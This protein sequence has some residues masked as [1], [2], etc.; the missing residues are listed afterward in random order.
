MSRR[1]WALFVVLGIV[2]GLPYLLIRVSV[3][4]VS[5]ALLVFVRT[6]GGAALLAPF[7]FRRGALRP[8]L[9]HWKP[10]VLYSAVE[11]AGP[12]LLLFNAE[13]RL[14][15]S[16]A[17]LLVAAVP[18][19]GAGLAQVTGTDRLDRHRT[20]GL[21]LGIAGVA[22]LVG[23]DVRGS[24]L[25]SALSILVVAAGYALGPWILSRHLSGLPAMAVVGGSLVLCAALYAPVV[26][27]AL[28][29]RPLSGE[30]VA[31]MAALTVVCTV[32][33]FLVF[34]ALIAEVGAL[35]ATVITYVNTAVA[36]LLGVTVLGEHFGVGT[37]VGFVLILGGSFL[38]T[39]PLRTT[40][41]AA[42]PATG[43]AAAEDVPAGGPS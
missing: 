10:L 31:A 21:A 28:P 13:R 2:W 1:G 18:I 11:I 34:Y 26:P 40:V 4:E 15:S 29:S 7:A 42:A 3:R 19:I 35:R 27:F 33:A 30:V 32:V 39:R 24:S 36:V 5:P 23:V 25:L 20:L 16:L 38:A 9:R 6:A 43:Q 37:A 22:A 12:W 8:L 41:L 14:S 17:G